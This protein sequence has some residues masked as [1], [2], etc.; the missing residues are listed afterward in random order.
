MAATKCRRKGPAI[1]RV[2]VPCRAGEP[3]RPIICHQQVKLALLSSH[4]VQIDVQVADQGCL[5]RR[6]ARLSPLN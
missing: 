3:G 1:R 6:P 2:A 4:L 5:E